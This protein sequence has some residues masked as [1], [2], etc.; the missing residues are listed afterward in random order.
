MLQPKWLHVHFLTVFDTLRYTIHLYIALILPHTHTYQSLTEKYTY[1]YLLYIFTI[2]KALLSITSYANISIV[3][4]T[5]T[6][7]ITLELIHLDF[8]LGKSCSTPSILLNVT[9]PSVLTSTV[10]LPFWTILQGKSQGNE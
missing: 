8:N 3:L 10:S 5:N 6:T 1:H 7:T 9:L 4:F 2:S